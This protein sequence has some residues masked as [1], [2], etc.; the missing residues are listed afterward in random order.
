MANLLFQN[1][2]FSMNLPL[3]SEDNFSNG[4]EGICK[5]TFRGPMIT[6]AAKAHLK[7]SNIWKLSFREKKTIKNDDVVWWNDH[8]QLIN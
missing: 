6:S 2:L 7:Y 1:S 8:D 5:H 4:M 3:N